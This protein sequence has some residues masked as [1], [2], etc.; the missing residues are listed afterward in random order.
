MDKKKGLYRQSGSVVLM[1]LIFLIMGGLLIPEPLYGLSF[2][3]FLITDLYFLIISVFVLFMFFSGQKK[4]PK[5]AVLQSF[6][7]I[8]LK[9]LVHMAFI[10]VFY[11]VT[12]NLSTHYIIVFFVLYLSFTL[13][14]LFSFKKELK[15][16]GKAG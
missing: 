15:E 1:F 13:F 2:K 8:S 7:I 6:A 3:Q 9:M 10:L 16:T 4:G 11:L 5:K 14:L 12:K